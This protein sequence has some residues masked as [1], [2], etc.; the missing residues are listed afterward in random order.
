MRACPDFDLSQ[1]APLVFA[2][3]GGGTISVK[4]APLRGAPGKDKKST[5]QFAQ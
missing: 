3:L 2:F 5:N 1:S 4:E